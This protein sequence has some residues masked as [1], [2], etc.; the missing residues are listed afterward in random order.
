[1]HLLIIWERGRYQQEKIIDDIKKQFKILD[2]YEI[3]WTSKKVA[4]NFTRF[5][6]VK[7]PN[8][9]FKEKECGKGSFLLFILWDESPIYEMRE[10]SHGNEMVNVKMF[11]S[12]T[13]YRSWTG[14]G[15][16]IHATNSPEET[17]HDITL[18]L[19]KNYED[20]INGKSKK[21]WDG[22]FISL[23]RDLTGASGW[24]D[25]THFFYVLNNTLRY[26]VLRGDENLNSSENSEEH[27]DIDLLVEN[28][29]NAVFLMN[30]IQLYKYP[31]RPKVAVTI[32]QRQYIFDLWDA[33]LKY[34]SMAWHE[35]MLSKRIKKGFYY[36]LDIEN[37]FYSRIYHCLIHKSK[38]AKDYYPYLEN[39]FVQLGL[40]R[41]FSL[42]E[43]Q[44]PMDLYYKLLLDYMEQHDYEFLKEEK[45][46]HCFFNSRVANIA[47]ALQKTKEILGTESISPYMVDANSDS[48]YIYFIGNFEGRKIFIKYGGVGDSC[49]NEYRMTKKAY[50][51]CPDHFLP[52]LYYHN[53]S[54]CRFIV[55]EFLESIPIIEYVNTASDTEVIEIQKQM[56]E[57]YYALV[58]CDLLHRDIRPDNFVVT[59]GGLLKLLDLQFAIRISNPLELNCV[60]NNKKIA[61][62]LGDVFRY[63]K[64]E[65]NDTYSFQET[66][67]KIGIEMKFEKGI[68]NNSYRIPLPQIIRF[69]LQNI[70]ELIWGG[71]KLLSTIILKYGKLVLKKMF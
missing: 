64:Y 52:I 4:S 45:D 63:K 56:D 67:D 10:T 8:R 58:D 66:C 69:K 2:V 42:K 30:G 15:H 43:Y 39:K 55:Y 40:D 65:W 25:L 26:V 32:N 14:G 5:Y 48:E 60:K 3:E 62:R 59:K 18:L 12:K 6:G 29:K 47:T 24:D 53:E 36:Y 71:Q 23:K 41:N 7:L 44:N 33:S 54:D 46:W 20:Y 35:A 11:D 70:G 17:N 19:G 61:L 57:I 22:S 38:T 13:K 37:D 9:S 27:A 21:E 68:A 34:H 31:I 51:K 16:K 50:E 49:E 28:Y 1:M